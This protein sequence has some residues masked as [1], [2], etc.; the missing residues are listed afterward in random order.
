[1]GQRRSRLIFSLKMMIPSTNIYNT[2]Q[3]CSKGLTRIFRCNFYIFLQSKLV[4]IQQSLCNI[5]FAYFI[6]IEAHWMRTKSSLEFSFAGEATQK[7]TNSKEV[8]F[9]SHHI[10]SISSF[11]LSSHGR[12]QKQIQMSNKKKKGDRMKYCRRMLWKSSFR[13]ILYSGIR[14]KTLV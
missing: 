3:I 7:T 13:Y 2:S 9:I 14:F 1:M 4:Q 6:F 12:F 11:F 8:S 10:S 5:G